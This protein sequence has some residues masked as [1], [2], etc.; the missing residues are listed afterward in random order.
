MTVKLNDKVAKAK[1][2]LER[3]KLERRSKIKRIGGNSRI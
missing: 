2:E 1:E 3:L